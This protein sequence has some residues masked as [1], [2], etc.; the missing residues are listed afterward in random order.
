MF[1]DQAKDLL[2][3]LAANMRLHFDCNY[4]EDIHAVFVETEK[5]C[6]PFRIL[7]TIKR[8]TESSRC[9]NASQL[10]IG[11]DKWSGSTSY[12]NVQLFET[13]RAD[14]YVNSPYCSKDASNNVT[15]ECHRVFYC[16]KPKKRRT[17]CWIGNRFRPNKTVDQNF[18][19]YHN[20]TGPRDLCLA[21]F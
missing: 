16:Q 7:F 21:D 20:G 5:T 2:E 9:L 6:P 17:V 8:D 14:P 10:R 15:D 19:T 11:L 4:E 3:R 13:Y 12:G 1:C 18:E